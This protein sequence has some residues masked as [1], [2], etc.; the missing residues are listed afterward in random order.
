MRLALTPLVSSLLCFAAGCAVQG[1]TRDEDLATQ[2]AA[3]VHLE[4]QEGS[5]HVVARYVRAASVTPEAVRATGGTFD[6]PALGQCSPLDAHASGPIAPVELLAAGNTTLVQGDAVV[7]LIPRSIPD[8]SDLVSGFVYSKT[9]ELKTGPATLMLAG[10]SEPIAIELPAVLG[11]VAVDGQRGSLELDS[12]TSVVRVTWDPA[13]AAH[14]SLILADVYGAAIAVRCTFED[15]GAGELDR[16]LFG[17]RGALVLRRL[18]HAEL[19]REP[20]QRVVIDSETS[21]T[22]PYRGGL[23]REPAR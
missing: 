8:M 11:N 17:A 16:S 1:E 7:E 4:R 2:S 22:L 23:D 13:P 20:F 6:L 5:S 9:A 15:S 10:V 3:L 14:D 19:E 21:R 18:V 12:S